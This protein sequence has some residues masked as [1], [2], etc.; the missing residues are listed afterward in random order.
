MWID[1]IILPNQ[2]DIEG[3]IYDLLGKIEE[4]KKNVEQLNNTRLELVKYRNLLWLKGHA[5]EDIVTDAFKYLS[6]TDIRRERSADLEDGIFNF[7][8]SSEYEYGILE[9]KGSDARTSM[10]DLTQCEKWVT[11]Y[12][13]ENKKGKGIFIP[14]QHRLQKYPDSINDKKHFEPNEFDYAKTR[15]ICILPTFEIF[16]AVTEKMNNNPEITRE[17][18]EKKI[19]SSNGLCKLI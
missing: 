17:N 10:A 3:K 8:N 19:L 14:N 7:E 6:F 1:E 2:N 4:H 13:L 11:D 18:I 12:L 9:V 16:K 15:K 5:L